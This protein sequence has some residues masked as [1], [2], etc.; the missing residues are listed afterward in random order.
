MTLH[1]GLV[2]ALVH[3]H[4]VQLEVARDALV[5]LDVQVLIVGLVAPAP[6][7]RGIAVSA[8]TADELVGSHLQVARRLLDGVHMREVH[9]H[10]RAVLTAEQCLLLERVAQLSLV[11]PFAFGMRGVGVEGRQ[12]VGV[13]H[14]EGGQVVQERRRA[15][16]GAARAERHVVRPLGLQQYA[17][18]ALRVG[19]GKH[20]HVAL[21]VDVAVVERRVLRLLCIFGQHVEATL[22][23]IGAHVPGIHVLR[24][25]Q[26]VVGTHADIVLRGLLVLVHKR[27]AE[28]QI[29]ASFGH[30]LNPLVDVQLHVATR[31][32][33]VVVSP[34]AA[35]LAGD[36]L[37]LHTLDGL[38]DHAAAQQRVVDAQRALLVGAQDETRTELLVEVTGSDLHVFHRATLH[39]EVGHAPALEVL[40]EAGQRVLQ[41]LEARAGIHILALQGCLDVGVGERPVVGV[42]GADGI[43]VLRN[44]DV[45]LYATRQR[46]LVLIVLRTD[47]QRRQQSQRHDQ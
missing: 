27:G 41:K 32:P 3:V 22:R 1:D 42:L 47:V 23:Q 39:V 34:V 18:S 17:Q 12:R 33:R 7:L 43:V 8:G 46:Y 38:I 35:L 15:V 10:A 30:R 24:Q 19:A 40:L 36:G 2:I 21:A 29:G 14:G 31:H 25:V 6:E 37:Q 13:V 45:A 5:N 11:G 16:H 26:L 20:G 44:E 4:E 28:R 9:L